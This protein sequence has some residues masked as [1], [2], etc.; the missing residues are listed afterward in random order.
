V[1]IHGAYLSA[2]YRHLL[3]VWLGGDIAPACH[4]IV[5][6]SAGYGWVFL[7]TATLTC[8]GIRED[9]GYVTPI[10]R[11]VSLC[12]YWTG[13]FAYVHSSTGPPARAYHMVR[14]DLL[15]LRSCN[16]T[17]DLPNPDM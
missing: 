8:L 5:R 15:R 16:E 17:T 6:P 7:D 13:L 11:A 4:A 12:L 9:E 2:G 14:K 1:E 10:R 3:P